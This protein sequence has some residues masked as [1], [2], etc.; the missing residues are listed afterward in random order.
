MSVQLSLQDFRFT[1]PLRV[2]WGEVDMQKVVFNPHY[3]TY[4]DTA[5]GGYWRALAFPYESTLE[6]LGGD[7]FVK[8]STIEYFA[9]ARYDDL[10]NIGV[11]CQR[12]G[13][14]SLTFQVAIFRGETLL[15]LVELIYVFANPKTARSVPIPNL[16]KKALEDFERREPITHLTMG[17]WSEFQSQVTPLRMRVFVAEQGVHESLEIDEQDPLSLHVALMNSLGHCVATARLLPAIEGTSRIGRMAVE[18]QLR[19]TGLGSQVLQALI[20]KSR[21]RGDRSVV[22]HAQ[23]SAQGFYAK[24]GFSP[25]GEQFEEAGIA[26]IEMKLALP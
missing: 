18:R 25:N 17:H 12:I 26:H 6:S 8:K 21:E 15:T 5:M 9:S 10:L 20:Q 19:G 2:R 11:K 13:N 16:A 23:L 7:L 3:L 14:S 22:L 1:Y 4:A 24:A